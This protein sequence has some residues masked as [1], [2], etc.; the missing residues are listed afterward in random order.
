MIYL[1]LVC[2]LTEPVAAPEHNASTFSGGGQLLRRTAGDGLVAAS[3][4]V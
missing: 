4:R 3:G 2:S 1:L